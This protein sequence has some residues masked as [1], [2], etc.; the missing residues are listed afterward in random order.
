MASMMALLNSKMGSSVANKWVGILFRS[1][2]RPMQRNDF[3]C[4]ICAVSCCVV[5]VVVFGQRSEK[6]L[7]F[8]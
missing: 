2:S 8:P 4:L 6:H 7:V 1:T 5:M 3:L